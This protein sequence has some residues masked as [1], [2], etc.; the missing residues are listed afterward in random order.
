M[1]PLTRYS[2][3]VSAISFALI[4]LAPG[5]LQLA[6][7]RGWIRQGPAIPVIAKSLA[8]GFFFLFALGIVPG[9]LTLFLGGQSGIG[10]SG[11]SMVRL[12]RDHHAGV[13]LVVW[14]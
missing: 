13:T 4:F 8:L 9:V 3:I 12:I 5:G 6:A 1:N 10:N 7:A 14:A 2:L 11:L